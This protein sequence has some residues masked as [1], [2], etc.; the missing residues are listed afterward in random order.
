MR[1]ACAESECDGKGMGTECASQPIR[2][3]ASQAPQTSSTSGLAPPSFVNRCSI[4]AWT[5][6]LRRQRLC[7]ISLPHH[8]LTLV[9]DPAA[10]ST[11]SSGCRNAR[12]ARCRCCLQV[13]SKPSRAP[14]LCL[15]CQGTAPP[16]V[17]MADL[18]RMQPDALTVAS[19]V[20][21][22]AVP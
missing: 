10:S 16:G 7:W 17:C 12:L 8:P 13:D 2:S 5:R 22:P 1:E 6:L 21:N 4:I 11:A 3:L 20:L 19:C 14:A 9:G 15:H 18:Q